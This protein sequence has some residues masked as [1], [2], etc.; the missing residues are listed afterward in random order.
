MTPLIDIAFLILIFF[1][2]LPFKTLE[3][4]LAAF[5]PT[6]KGIAP[7]NEEPPV[8]IKVQ[9]HILARK[10]E[11]R[12]WG[13]LDKMVM[14][15]TQVRYKYNE[16]ETESMEEVGRWI[17]E[18]MKQR[19]NDSDIKVVGEIKAAHKIPH[20]FVVA[21]LNKF[22][23]ADMAQVDFFGTAIPGKRLRDQPALPYPIKNY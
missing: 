11:K 6:D 20:M 16:R 8:E 10:E 7:T 9:I 1:M 23:E 3:G 4:K 12:K 2:C 19:E 17:K 5:L 15:P 18:A 13:P 14:M 22:K 21:V